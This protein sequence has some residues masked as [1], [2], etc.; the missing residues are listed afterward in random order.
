[1]TPYT[2]TLLLETEAEDSPIFFE[3]SP[4]E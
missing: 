4:E 3:S 1:M 2:T